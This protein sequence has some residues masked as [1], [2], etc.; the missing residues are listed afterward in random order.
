MPFVRIKI[1]AL[2]CLSLLLNTA[3]VEKKGNSSESPGY[4]ELII[5]NFSISLPKEYDLAELDLNKYVFDKYVQF[6]IVKN[7]VM[8]LKV[9][10][11]EIGHLEGMYRKSDKYDTVITDTIQGHYVQMI[12]YGKKSYM[13]DNGYSLGLY[14]MD[15]VPDKNAPAPEEGNGNSVDLQCFCHQKIFSAWT[16]KTVCLTK[17]E[18]HLF[19]ES[20]RKGKIIEEK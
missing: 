15:L 13:M 9:A 19:I 8:K 16:D 4:H 14:I 11:T 3:C 12:S 5:N 7:D 2:V 10:F 1:G 20:F 17:A 18:L 6:I